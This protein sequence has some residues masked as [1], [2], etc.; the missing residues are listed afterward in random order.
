MEGIKYR[1]DVV[2]EDIASRIQAGTG[3]EMPSGALYRVATL[4]PPYAEPDG[5]I[6][7][8]RIGPQIARDGARAIDRDGEEIWIMPH[9]IVKLV[10]VALN[11]RSVI[12]SELVKGA[13]A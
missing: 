1:V 6:L 13:S 3:M 2:F 12:E 8:S 11:E 5:K 7:L 4:V 9:R 10:P